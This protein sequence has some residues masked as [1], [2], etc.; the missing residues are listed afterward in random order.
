MRSEEHKEGNRE[1]KTGSREYGEKHHG[2]V[3][4]PE[5]TVQNPKLTRLPDFSSARVVVVGDIMLD[6]YVWGRVSRVSPEAPVPVL[7]CLEKTMVLGGAANV[8]ANLAGLGAKVCLAGVCGRDA[9]GTRIRSL[10]KDQAITDLTLRVKDVSTITKTRIMAQNQ[11]LLRI[12]QEKIEPVSEETEGLVFK[13]L[14]DHIT[15]GSVLVLSDYAK[16]LLSHGLCRRL[17]SRS[18]ASGALVL[19]D[20]KGQDWEKY[21]QADCLTPNFD[22][23]K[24]YARIDSDREDSFFSA[25][26]NILDSLEAEKM[27][28]TRG[29]KGLVLFQK[30]QP[31]L[32]IAAR[33]RE[34]FDVSGA[35]D[36]VLAA[37]AACLGAGSGWREAAGIANRAAG[38][39]VGKL[40]TRPVQHQE[41]E[42]DFWADSEKE[43]RVVTLKA[44]LNRILQWRERKQTVVFTNG[45]FDL[46]H[47]GHI[48]LL[49]TAA[50]QG[51]RLVVGLN[52]DGSVAKLKG[53]HRPLLTQKDRAA[54][55]AA[56]ES[57]D[58]VIVFEEPTPLKLI[59]QIKPDVLVKGADY[60][61][62]QVVGREVV[63]A[64][65]GEVVLVDLEEGLSTTKLLEAIKKTNS[66][67]D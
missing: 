55:L 30:E 6:C 57:V 37:L 62:K 41:L 11:Q 15:P 64:C 63:E 12:D 36:T 48:K 53:P 14:Q 50:T 24:H 40:G 52:S 60:A 9:E 27:V 22:E 19:V 67:P 25:A 38:I 28:L 20:P 31:P 54:I 44:G 56:L 61:G 51:D 1:R 29:S 3:S 66:R 33:A 43:G 16:G 65:G 42:N 34:V 58:L 32:A 45:C 5:S 46:L 47:P 21:R 4:R 10:L 23:L 2:A 8:A 7:Q 17:I 35:G 18:R 26:G 39:V 13:A 49:Q 59:E